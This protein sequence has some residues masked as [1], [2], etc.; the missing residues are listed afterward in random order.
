MSFTGWQ[1]RP[2][3]F[4]RQ[5]QENLDDSFFCSILFGTLLTN[6]TI[7]DMFTDTLLR[8]NVSVL[9]AIIYIWGGIFDLDCIK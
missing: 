2:F 7:S 9:L 5:T 6:F 8:Q 3:L 4:M 1:A